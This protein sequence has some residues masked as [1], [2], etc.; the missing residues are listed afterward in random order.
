MMEH[1]EFLLLYLLTFIISKEEEIYFHSEQRR[2]HRQRLQ[3]REREREREREGKT[4]KRKF[5][6]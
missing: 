5:R 3:T 6:R 4:E 2:Q 1:Q